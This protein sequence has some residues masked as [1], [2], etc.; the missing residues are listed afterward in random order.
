MKQVFFQFVL[1]SLIILFINQKHL[2]IMASVDEVKKAVA[3][4]QA[5]V[6]TTQEAIAVAIKALEAQIVAGA[7]PAQLQEIVDSLKAVQTDVA[8]TPTV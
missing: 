6:D 1:F 8:G 7:T 4:L 3:D 5:T 2:L